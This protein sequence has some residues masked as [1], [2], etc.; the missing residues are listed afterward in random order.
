MWEG[1]YKKTY[2]GFTAK[3]SGLSWPRLLFNKMG[4]RQHDYHAEKTGRSAT[5]DQV[6][7]CEEGICTGQGRAYPLSEM[8]T[9][10]SNR[11][12]LAQPHEVLPQRTYGMIT[13]SLHIC[14]WCGQSTRY[15]FV[16]GHYECMSCRRPVF[17][18]CDGE[19]MYETDKNETKLGTSL[20]QTRRT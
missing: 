10:V 13:T 2:S 19:R 7:E 1:E 12:R 8:W 6:H 9:E 11:K 18:C 14:P 5:G 3:G 20:T 17:D 4:S 16:R 15:E